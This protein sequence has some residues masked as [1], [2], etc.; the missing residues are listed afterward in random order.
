MQFIMVKKITNV[1][2]VERH[3]LEQNSWWYTSIQFIKAK[4]ITNV[5][6]V[7]NHFLHQDT[8]RNTFIFNIMPKCDLINLNKNSESFT[9]MILRRLA[10]LLCTITKCQQLFC[11]FLPHCIQIHWCFPP[12]FWKM[13]TS[14]IFPS[15]QVA[16]IGK[17]MYKIYR[18][19]NKCIYL[20][21]CYVDI[22]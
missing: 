1:T 5:I 14:M 17:I 12:Y 13:S 15:A 11:I 8:W 22:L 18:W 19:K 6:F 3:F 4:K 7:E 10:G 16:L 9:K 2:H 20:G 21:I